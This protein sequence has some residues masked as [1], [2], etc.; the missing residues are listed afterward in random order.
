MQQI[1]RL[2][3]KIYCG[4][5]ITKE[6]ALL[7]YETPLSPLTAAA[8]EIR[9]R[10]CGNRFDLCA[11]LNAK[12]GRCSEDCKFCAQ[13]RRHA[14]K[15]NAYPLLSKEKIVS[16]AK[17]EEKAGVKRFAMVTSG[18]H[19]SEEEIDSI[20]R[21]T[22]AVKK[23]TALSLCASV[24][25]LH[26]AQLEKMK[27]AGISR[28]HNNLETSR[29]F[30]PEICT[31]HSY[32]EKIATISAA[33]DAGLTVCSGGILGLGETVED[34]IDLALTLKELEIKSV[35]INILHAIPGTSLAKTP[36][37]SNEEILRTIAVFRFLL[38]DAFLRLAGGRGNQA[39]MGRA[40]FGAGANAAITG[41]LLTTAGISVA[42]DLLMLKEMDYEVN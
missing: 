9:R 14:T 34:R 11:I 26:K 33:Q 38:P 39:D 10:F 35:P 29:R 40:C 36:P 31:S 2:K 19:L 1:T 37:L 4:K 6:E 30:F 41:D 7:L 3:E 20:C 21:S 28:I 18:K 15:I 22:K 17:G 16:A 24:G 42:S 5:S 12:S 13:S 23:A 27:A 8:D 25:L 32:D